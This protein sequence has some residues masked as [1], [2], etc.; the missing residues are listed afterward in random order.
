L[1]FG[2]TY[3][4]WRERIALAADDP[5]YAND[6]HLAALRALLLKARTGSPFYREL[7]DM[8]FGPPRTSAG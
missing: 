5:Q 6:Q 1:K 3:R 4:Q 8:A 2:N 7:I